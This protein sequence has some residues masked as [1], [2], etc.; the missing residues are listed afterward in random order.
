MKKKTLPSSFRDPS[1]FLFTRKG[2]LYRQINKSYQKNYELLVKSGLYK[3]L[4][5]KELLVKHQE[6]KSSTPSPGIFRIIKPDKVPFISYPYEWSFS[7]LQDAALLTLSVQKIALIH[8]MSLKDAS[9]F[10]VQFVNGKPVF[11]DTLS[12]EKY[13]E[14]KPWI[15]Y[16]Q[17]CQHFLAPLAL[18]SKVEIGL[19]QLL[20]NYIDGIPLP[21]TSKLLPKSTYASFSLLT[22]IHLHARGQKHY[23]ERQV[24]VK[25]K[26]VNKQSLMALVTN[27]ES[28]VKGLNWNPTNTPWAN[29]YEDTNYSKI[30]MKHKKT[31]VKR[32]MY[33]AKPEKLV[34]DLGA[35]TGDF[36]R[37][38]KEGK[39]LVVSLDLDPAA[40]EKNYLKVKSKSEKNILPLLM[41]L[42][43]P[44]ASIGWENLERSSLVDRGP[45]DLALALALVHH[46][47]IGNNLPFGKIASF[48]AKCTQD[49]IIEF[50]PKNDSNAKRLLRAREDIF[51]SYSKRHFEL[52]FKKYFTISSAVEIKGSKRIL[53][54]MSKIS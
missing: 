46:L 13:I 3:D 7:Q 48:F 45:A 17:F 52:E 40:V 11:I 19:G 36:S 51:S 41:D 47:A 8:Q 2:V 14:G 12:F 54:L 37:L 30:A 20:K 31:L 43:S 50:I 39:V 23:S 32:F 22:H 9:S 26:K 49:L 29:Y 38:V 25:E 53:Y 4:T 28:A 34:W 18:M 21:L 16:K 33:R 15:A 10:N 44:S 5:T 35:N 27:L 42:N 1:G 24:N 6:T